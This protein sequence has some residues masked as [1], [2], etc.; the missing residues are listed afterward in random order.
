[1]GNCLK[2][3]SRRV[4]S[5]CVPSRRQVAPRKRIDR[6][7]NV[8][9][10]VDLFN[11][12]NEGLCTELTRPKKYEDHHQYFHGAKTYFGAFNNVDSPCRICTEDMPCERHI[13]TVYNCNNVNRIVTVDGRD[14]GLDYC[15]A[16]NK[17]PHQS[18]RG[19]RCRTFLKSGELACKDHICHSKGCSGAAT[20]GMLCALHS[21]TSTDNWTCLV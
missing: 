12:N 7:D 8:V 16:H 19:K 15:I 5:K 21:D 9:S 20:E 11:E 2:P 1:M 6:Y 17:C 13:C 3:Q 18:K 14:F 10:V 4:K